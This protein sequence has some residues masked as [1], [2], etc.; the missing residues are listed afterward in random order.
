MMHKFLLWKLLGRQGYFLSVGEEVSLQSDLLDAEI[1][2]PLALEWLH[3]SVGHVVLQEIVL[4]VEDLRAQITAKQPA[5]VR[6]ANWRRWEC[7]QEGH[8][9][10]ARGQK[11]VLEEE[12]KN[13][14]ETSGKMI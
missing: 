4:V 7:A 11:V 1:G 13:K 8:M 5:I 12:G 2:T 14:E 3:S 6:G 10:W 9:A